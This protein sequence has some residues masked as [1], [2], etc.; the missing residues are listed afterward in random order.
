MKLAIMQPYFMPYIGYFQLA[1]TVDLFVLYDNIKYTKRGWINRN[2]YLR[3]GQE[4]MLSL[5]LAR[6]SDSLH[7]RERTLSPSFD[8]RR[9]LNRLVEAY[10]RAPMFE[11]ALPLIETAVLNAE[12]NLFGYIRHSLAETFGYLAIPTRMIAS[13]EVPIDHTLRAQDKVIALCHAVGATTYVNAPGGRELYSPHAFAAEG[14]KLLF[15]NPPTIQYRQF[16]HDFVPQLSI[17]DVLM[18]NSREQVQE[19]IRNDRDSL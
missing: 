11:E 1:A 3:H 15:L 7:V 17:I 5:P 18:F 4:A 8:R 14:I 10:R 2:R 16:Q 12:P 6:D 9:L 13:S 19:Y